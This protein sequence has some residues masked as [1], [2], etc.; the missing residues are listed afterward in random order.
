M[1]AGYG[2]FVVPPAAND[3]GK[4]QGDDEAQ[5]HDC[6]SHGAGSGSEGH[7]E[8]GL[9][10][11]ASRWAAL[12]VMGMMGVVGYHQAGQRSDFYTAIDG[13]LCCNSSQFR[14][15]PTLQYAY[16]CRRAG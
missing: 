9:R 12:A 5:A 11:V 4:L 14:Y 13:E 16:A 1:S 7:R 8:G 10:T 6:S 3:D 15:Q 2:A